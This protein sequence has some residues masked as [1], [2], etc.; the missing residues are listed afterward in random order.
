MYV[1][2]TYSCLF[3]FACLFGGFVCL[4]VCFFPLGSIPSFTHSQID[5]D[6]VTLHTLIFMFGKLRQPEKAFEFFAEMLSRGV[7]PKHQALLNFLIGL[8]AKKG[9]EDAAFTLWLQ[10][11]CRWLALSVCLF[12]FVFVCLFVFFCFF[13]SCFACVCFILLFVLLVFD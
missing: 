6:E 13:S 8:H 10:V 12:C 3:L 5:P 9:D 4:V 7:T 2:E 11:R 1:V